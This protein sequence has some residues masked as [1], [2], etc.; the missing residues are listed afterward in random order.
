MGAPLWLLFVLFVALALGSGEFG[1]RWGLRGAHREGGLTG[2]VVGSHLALVSFMFAMAFGAS[3]SRLQARRDLTVR[4]A[5]AIGTAEL[6]SRML[7]R[8]E[9]QAI[10]RILIDY[11]RLRAVLIP[12]GQVDPVEGLARSRAAMS[13]LWQETLHA[14]EVGEP[15]APML[16]LLVSSVNEVIDTGAERVYVVLHDR[17]PAAIWAGLVLVSLSGFVVLGYHQGARR[18]RIRGAASLAVALAVVLALIEDL[19]RPHSGLAKIQQSS[20]LDVLGE[21]ERYQPSP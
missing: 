11:A 6:R 10:R 20:M 3:M 2:Y 9:A 4:E 15:N 14:V 18:E 1:Y 5:N 7:P 16:T 12:Q 19:D 17:I 13:A 8:A 21:M